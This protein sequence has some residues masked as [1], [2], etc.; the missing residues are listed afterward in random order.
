M[1]EQNRNISASLAKG[2][3]ILQAFDGNT[4]TLSLA[5]LARRT[6]QDRATARRGALTLVTAGLLQQ[7]GRAFSLAP[8]ILALTGSF[9][10]A[11]QFGRLVQP[12]LNH[13]A[14]EMGAEIVL[15]LRDGGQVLMLAQSTVQRGPVSHGFTTGSHLPLL[16]T[17]LGRMLL[18]CEPEAV[19]TG[20]MPEDPLPG[21]TARSL[22]DRQ[23]VLN[24]IRRA[25]KDG[26]CITDGE[27]EVGIRGISVPVPK[28]ES[29]PL[30]VGSSFPLGRDSHADSDIPLRRL[31]HCAADI[32]ASGVLTGAQ[33]RATRS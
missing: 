22:P 6:G 1:P 21:H 33:F 28:P 5:E 12:V 14:A 17:S 31:Q 13:H 26:Y 9:L 8:R 23:S 7:N 25:R 2:L 24:R 15:A 30:A 11:H 20:L 29:V 27:F 4:L 19:A 32:R 10:Q 3:A 18:A 16:H